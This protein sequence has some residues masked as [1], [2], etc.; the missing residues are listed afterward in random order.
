MFRTLVEIF[1]QLVTNAET[2]ILKLFEFG[3]DFDPFFCVFK[4]ISFIFFVKRRFDQATKA[5]FR[6]LVY[7]MNRSADDR[8]Q[9]KL[10]LLLWTSLRMRKHEAAWAVGKIHILS[11]TNRWFLDRT[12]SRFCLKNTFRFWRVRS[13]LFY[14]HHI[15]STELAFEGVT[16]L[17]QRVDMERSTKHRWA[18][19]SHNLSA[20]KCF[21]DYLGC[22]DRFFDDFQVTCCNGDSS[23]Q[24]L[25]PQKTEQ[26]FYLV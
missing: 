13:G 12:P 10:V 16:S 3:Y 22:C 25:W 5:T 7:L 23:M 11:W 8:R 1:L 26:I 21:L 9:T 2:S 19:Q 4:L 15:E 6:F 20:R 14:Y 18:A 24:Q 17:L